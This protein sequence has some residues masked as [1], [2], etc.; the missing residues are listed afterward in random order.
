M[1]FASVP[2]GIN[3]GPVE[4]P[5]IIHDIKAEYVKV[6]QMFDDACAMEES[7]TLVKVKEFC[8]DLI[9]CAFQGIPRI[10]HHKDDIERANTLPEL[11]RVVCFRLSHWVS[12]DFFK[13][14]IAHFQPALKSVGEQLM[15]YEDKL[16]PI[17]LE[18]LKH[19][20]ELQK[21]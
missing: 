9:E 8:I 14:V 19:I 4:R 16:K 11:A 5:S 21:R 10:T 17:L 1:L 6:K 7:L 3:D 2:L 15:L 12:Y 20:A 18:K 13:K